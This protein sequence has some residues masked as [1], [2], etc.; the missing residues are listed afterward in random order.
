DAANEGIT[1]TIVINFKLNRIFP[2]EIPGHA[3]QAAASA[4]RT[5]SEEF[6]EPSQ[7]STRT[8]GPPVPREL[9]RFQPY[10]LGLLYCRNSAKFADNRIRHTAIHLHHGYCLPRRTNRSFVASAERKVRN[11]DSVLA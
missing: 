3:A 7:H 2:F 11:V 1:R 9:L 6:S 4:A 5:K 8:G 10:G